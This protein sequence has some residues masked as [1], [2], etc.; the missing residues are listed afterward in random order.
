MPDKP[1]QEKK[2][3]TPPPS[4]RRGG[5]RH[6]ACFPAYVER[7]AGAP[8]ASM[9]QNLSVTGALLLS[10]KEL[11][12]GDRVRLQ[13][14]IFED[15]KE[16]RYASGRVVRSEPLGEDAIGLWTCRIGIQFDE[17][18]TACESDIVALAERQER[19]RAG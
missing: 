7:D 17:P 12:A 3:S 9:I 6:I 19:L 15:I 13:L 11:P 1:M 4:D 10:R 5:E 14:F 2:E 16:F 8:R 18:L